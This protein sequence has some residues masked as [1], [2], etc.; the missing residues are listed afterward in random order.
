[1]GKLSYKYERIKDAEQREKYNEN[2]GEGL[3]YLFNIRENFSDFMLINK[4]IDQ[5]F[6]NKHNLYVVG[7]R[8]NRSKGVWEYYVKS[9][10]ADEYKKIL[11]DSLYH[12]PY[13]TVDESKSGKKEL[14]LY[15]HFEGKPLVKEYIG[16]T[17]LGLEY[18]YGGQVQLETSELDMSNIAVSYD[19]ALSA[20]ESGD[21]EPVFTR[22]LYAMKD[23]ILSRTVL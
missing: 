8:L 4:F 13:I 3:D 5:D 11:N 15:H 14:Y 19:N 22:V 1:M 12:P 21:N 23:K 18:L 7:K 9:R 6:V 20:A 17:M 2:T 16:N 10:N